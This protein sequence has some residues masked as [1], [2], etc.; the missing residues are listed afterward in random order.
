[1]SSLPNCPKCSSEYTYEDG[2]LLV[3]PVC[4]HEWAAESEINS[5]EDE[6]VIKDSN[7]NVLS[8]GDT[9]SVIKDLKVKG[10]SS[11]IKIGTKVKNIRLVDGDHDIDCKIDGFGAMKLKSEF[12]KKV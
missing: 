9:V 11:V 12:V 1:M 10:S 8:D 5:L 6:K 2:V 4:A 3:C 7:G